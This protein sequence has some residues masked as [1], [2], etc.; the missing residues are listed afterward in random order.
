MSSSLLEY[1]GVFEKFLFQDLSG[2]FHLDFKNADAL[3]ALTCTL[4]KKDFNLE[5]EIP[6]NRLIPTVPLR[7]NYILWLE[8]LL[9]AMGEKTEI[10]GLD[11]GTGTSCIYPLLGAR[12][13]GWKFVATESEAEACECAQK[14]VA[15]N[16]LGDSIKVLR[17][18]PE[19]TF[20][21]AVRQTGQQFDFSMCNPPFFLNEF[22][23][24]SVGK[25]RS[26]F[27]PQPKGANS[28]SE[29][30]A[31]TDGGEVAFVQKMIEDSLHL[32]DAI[33]I[34]T[35]ML[36]K[37]QS[38]NAVKKL[39]HELTG[40][41]V[42]SMAKTEFCQGRTMRWGIA[43]T[44]SPD[45][46]LDR[47]MNPKEKPAKPMSFVVPKGVGSL[48]SLAEKVTELLQTLKISFAELKRDKQRISL[49]CTAMEN[50]WS[51]QR[52]KRRA[53]LISEKVTDG[54]SC[55][56]NGAGPNK[57]EIEETTTSAGAWK[58]PKIEHSCVPDLERHTN[59]ATEQ[60]PV[61]ECLLMLR[62]SD[63]ELLFE[64]QYTGGSLGKDSVQQ[65]LQYFKNRLGPT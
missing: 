47:V 36:G 19:S 35:T 59:G 65:I 25:G 33:K 8:D 53:A 37:K 27:R 39:L 41:S 6:E 17:V 55:S 11:I 24:S 21:E 3:R 54:N 26:P 4:L 15:V 34:Y 30:E 45:I 51:N 31:I 20:Q 46:K 32:K 64:I 16:N 52:R 1:N 22:D 57:G 12:K 56:V 18:N 40:G 50:T 49:K 44:F 42:T 2:R 9:S 28:P 13:N 14:N 23:A 10:F 63:S 58:K 60:I 29:H 62:L 5:V 61:V 48:E 7:L 38:V 43:W